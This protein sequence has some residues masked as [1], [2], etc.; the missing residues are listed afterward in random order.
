MILINMSFEE[1]FAENYRLLGEGN[2]FTWKGATYTTDLAKDG[3][4]PTPDNNSVNNPNSTVNQNNS[5]VNNKS[6]EQIQNDA[7]KDEINDQPELKNK[8]VKDTFRMDNV[9]SLAFLESNKAPLFSLIAAIG[10]T[11]DSYKSENFID[12]G[13]KE[14]YEKWSIKNTTD[15]AGYIDEDG[16][17]ISEKDYVEGEV[18]KGMQERTDAAPDVFGQAVGYDANL[19]TVDYKGGSLQGNYLESMNPD[20]SYFGFS[21]DT[22]G[23]HVFE[24]KL[25]TD[26]EGQV[27][28]PTGQTRYRS[29]KLI[30]GYE[31]DYSDDFI[32]YEP[33]AQQ[34]IDYSNPDFN[35][36]DQSGFLQYSNVNQSNQPTG[37][38][39]PFARYGGGLPK[40]QGNDQSEFFEEQGVIG[41]YEGQKVIYPEDY[42]GHIPDHGYF[43]T[44]IFASNRHYLEHANPVEV[45]IG[46]QKQWLLNQFNS[47]LMRNRYREQYKHVTGEYPSDEELDARLNA[48]IAFIEQ[49]PDFALQYPYTEHEPGT[50]TWDIAGPRETG[51]SRQGP[52][53]NVFDIDGSGGDLGYINPYS[54]RGM[55]VGKMDKR[56]HFGM[57]NFP[58]IPT[59]GDLLKADFSQD[60]QNLSGIHRYDIED[61]S[62]EEVEALAR[63]HNFKM[64]NQFQYPW[65]FGLTS[66]EHGDM[67]YKRN[68][69]DNLITHELG[70]TFNT[71]NSPL[72]RSSFEF[73]NPDSRPFERRLWQYDFQAADDIGERYP[74]DYGNYE[75]DIKLRGKLK[76]PYQDFIMNDLFEGYFNDLPDGALTHEAKYG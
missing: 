35:I 63:E 34:Y 39:D 64:P 73:P 21:Q 67:A 6:S 57:Y 69:L 32:S 58:L 56:N 72:F 30:T 3:S 48:Q 50:E 44:P 2:T 55:M 47:P 76:R 14:D 18:L 26:P 5:N 22:E 37:S 61:M 68:T 11:I 1:A 4:N 36:P 54:F 10:D 8:V 43:N 7:N 62:A 25:V 46:D 40:Y 29:D 13:S 53:V 60:L 19:K 70:H 41:D 42:E 38:S 24:N 65:M 71:D 66:D 75:E 28:S 15:K 49:G 45:G 51:F 52:I 33:N 74:D 59:A 23:K 27:Y 31:G 20:A 17:V 12:P 9:S 16:N